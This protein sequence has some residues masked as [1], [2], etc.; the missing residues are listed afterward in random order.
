MDG[1]IL[2]WI[3]ENMR[4]DI[5]NPIMITLTHLGD[6]GIIWILICIALLIRKK[7]RLIGYTA[8]FSL[9]VEYAITNLLLKNLV[10]RIRPYET[11]EGLNLLVAKADDFSFPSGHS[12]SSFAVGFVCFLLLPKRYGIPAIIL[13]ALIS[14]SRLYVGIHYPTDVLAGAAIGIGVAILACIGKKV[15]ESL[16]EK[17]LTK[18]I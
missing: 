12:G 14:F 18:S 17:R 8:G 5:L 4:N 15:Y 6:C 2:I 13:A 16:K 9:V 7:Y 1:Q 10:A 3:Q 11:V